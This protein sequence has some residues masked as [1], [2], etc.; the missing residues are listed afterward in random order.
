MIA[1]KILLGFMVA[2]LAASMARADE[3]EEPEETPGEDE[4][5]GED[6]DEG[7]DETV[8]E[9]KVQLVQ[10][11]DIPAPDDLIAGYD[12]HAEEITLTKG[13]YVRGELLMSSDDGFTA[14]TAAG[15]AEASE[16][17]ILCD[18]ITVPEDLTAQTAGYFSGTFNSKAIVIPYEESSDSDHET[19]INGLKPQLRRQGIFTI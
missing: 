15:I 13:E 6:D 7:D 14:A 17:C 8:S 16:V 18:D 3:P 9:Y 19:L 10:T 4:G 11:E 2:L 5:S 12:Y 1:A